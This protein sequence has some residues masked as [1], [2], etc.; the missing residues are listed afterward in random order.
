MR[1]LYAILIISSI[2]LISGVVLAL[3]SKFFAVKTDER[4]ERIRA[5]L[6]GANCGACGYAGCDGYAAAINEGSAKPDLCIP[7][8]S[9]TAA[10]LSTVLGIE[11]KSEKK[12]AFV[13]CGRTDNV[14]N[15]FAYN[16][17][18]SCAAANLLYGGPLSCKYGCIGMGDCEKACSYEA[19]S[20]SNGCAK[21]DKSICV[22]CGKCVCACPKGIISIVPCDN[23]CSVACSNPQKGAVARKVCEK[24]CIGCMKCVKLCPTGAISV[25]NC[26]ASIDSSKCIGCGEC[27]KACPDKC[28]V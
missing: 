10:A 24:A 6:P 13:K 3:A 23:A 2:G 25:T 18:Y 7:G 21:V 11:I 4:Q 28:I 17:N 26:L 9:A 12:V 16:G 8:A 5:C 19:I 22:G 27:A 1:V 15:E 14:T 20:V